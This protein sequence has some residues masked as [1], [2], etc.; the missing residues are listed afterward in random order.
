MTQ[1][2]IITTPANSQRGDSPKSAFDKCNANFTDLYGGAGFPGTPQTPAELAAGVTPVALNFFANP[3]LWVRREGCVLDGVT[4]DTAAFNKCLSVAAA[5]GAPNFALLID[6][7]MFI[8][9]AS[10]VIPQ[11]VQLWFVGAGKIK[12]GTGRTIT[13]GMTP[14]AGLWQIFDISAGGVILMPNNFKTKEVWAEWWGANGDGVT[15]IA[16]DVQIN[17][18]INAISNALGGSGGTVRFGAGRF[19][20][21]QVINLFD[22]CSLRGIN[23]FTKIIAQPAWVGGAVM[24]QASNAVG[25]HQMFD[26]RLEYLTVDAGAIAGIQAVVQSQGWQQRC[27]I[28]NCSI[29]NFTQFGLLYNHGFGGA[30]VLTLENTDFFCVDSNLAV[31]ALLVNDGTT[32]WMKVNVNNCAFASQGT[33]ANG[34]IGLQ[35]G[36]GNVGPAL[37]RIIC[38]IQGVDVEVLQY[39]IVL[40]GN[41]VLCGSGL[42][43]GGQT[44]AGGGNAIIRMLTTWSAGSGNPGSV[45]VTGA[46]IGGWTNMIVD[47]NRTYACAALEPYDGNLQ[48]PPNFTKPQGVALVTGGA[49]PVLGNSTSFGVVSKL[50]GAT[51]AHT[52][53]GVVTVTLSTTMDSSADIVATAVSQ[54]I[55]APDAVCNVTSATT[56]TVNTFSP[57]GVATNAASFLLNIFHT[58]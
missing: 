1:Q 2:Q 42:G 11:N 27:G 29:Q 19:L 45:N 33:G 6:G 10:I 46:K 44:P 7:P 21:S 31:C 12:P 4:D 54:D 36:S 56:L 47:S 32:G 18:A 50:L 22:Y 35:I 26:S 8:N 40:D 38:A 43:G 49:A 20:I 3:W 55:G 24:I 57:V 51:V 34:A 23:D 13:L 37:G 16:N 5:L 52:A 28:F 25:G 39:G 9:S 41:A 30:A 48:W 53:A 17:A 58:P 14:E 15:N